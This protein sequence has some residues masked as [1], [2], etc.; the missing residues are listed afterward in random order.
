MGRRGDA[1]MVDGFLEVAEQ[2]GWDLIPVAE[3]SALPS[4]TI[5]HVVFEQLWGEVEAGLR[6]A[7]AEGP[8]D[9][10]WLGLHGAAVTSECEDPEGELLRRIREVPGASA[11]PLFGVLR[12]SRH[13][14]PHDGRSCE[15][16]RVLPREPAYRRA[17]NPRCAR[18][19]F[20]PVASKK[21]SPPA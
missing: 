18:L 8:L 5:D 14:H 7:L 20:W 10:I 9:G 17:G 21:A 12:S 6:A 4:A 16:P 1:S 13:F 11:L 15:R 19:G 2:E 3:Y